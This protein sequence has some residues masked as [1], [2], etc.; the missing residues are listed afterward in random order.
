M[1]LFEG[2]KL[3]A[4][5]SARPP[6]EVIGPSGQVYRSTSIFCL[7]PHQQP[8]RAAI[9]LVEWWCFDPLILLTIIANCVTL[10]W[11]S[12]LDPPST[13]I[14]AC[15]M[16]FLV[17]FTAEMLSKILAYGF[18]AHEGAYLRNPWCQ[19]DFVIVT[20][21]WVP[22]VIPS[23]G[24]YSAFR[25]LRALRP[26]RTLKLISGMPML[27]E[28]VFRAMPRLF[29]VAALIGSV[30]LVFGI[31]GVELFKGQ[32]HYYCADPEDAGARSDPFNFHLQASDLCDPTREGQQC[33]TGLECLY[34]TATAASGTMNFDNIGGATIALMQAV[35]GDDYDIILHGL[36]N[37]FSP[38]AS[39]YFVSVAYYAR[40][41]LRHIPFLR[42]LTFQLPRSTC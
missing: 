40:P 28:S 14:N 38:S 10:A 7:R 23:F 12:P 35:T 30:L 22:I 21:A 41:S 32:L 36:D 37:T 2:A 3:D 9:Y 17:I 20:L 13:L 33:A 24:N 18:L 4:L 5:L 26:L 11:H 25:S 6:P 29:T 1:A 16:V 42:T 8:R 15:E 39:V 19:L 34:H 27:I 31:V